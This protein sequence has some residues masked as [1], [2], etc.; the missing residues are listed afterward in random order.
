MCITIQGFP[1]ISR[2]LQGPATEQKS[3]VICNTATH[4]LELTHSELN[5]AAVAYT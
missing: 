4:H 2:F 3:A 1:P 5:A